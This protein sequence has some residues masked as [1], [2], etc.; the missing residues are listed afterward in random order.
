MKRDTAIT[1]SEMISSASPSDAELLREQFHSQYGC[2]N[3]FEGATLID[4]VIGAGR[5]LAEMVGSEHADIGM[6]ALVRDLG[7]AVDAPEDWAEVLRDDAF[8]DAYCWKVGST[9]HN[10]NAYAYYGIALTGA[11]GA[12][13]REA[14]LGNEIELA[15]AFMAKVPFEA[16]GIDPADAGRTLRMARGRFALDTGGLVEPW[17]LAEFGGVSE[18][19][20]R[21][22]MAGSERVFDPKDGAVP[23]SQAL[24]WLKQRKQ[25]RQSTWRDQNTFEDLASVD[26]N[27]TVEEMLFVP[28]AA[29]GS[30]FHPGVGR[31]D[32]F[33]IG[34]VGRETTWP[35]FE[36]ALSTLQ[37][38]PDPV[39]RRPTPRGL[40][41]QARGV[42]WERMTR[43]ALDK[44]AGEMA[45]E[46]AART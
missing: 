20:I 7:Y 17:A 19:R 24:D 41:T 12:D 23:S 29:D 31:E 21:N 38:S 46:A 36:E 16:W 6:A 3:D 22:L 42:R 5:L 32:G 40:R 2:G 13:E 45:D 27:E 14:Y 37:R 35:N 15:D 11:S 34:P 25:F 9:F 4:V 43:A 28:V 39:W 26:R 8:G 44:M 18:R 33:T 10:L 1:E 30:T